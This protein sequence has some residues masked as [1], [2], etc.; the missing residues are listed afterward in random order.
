MAKRF[1]VS[2]SVL[3]SNIDIKFWQCSR[4]L[5]PGVYSVD[6]AEERGLLIVLFAGY[7]TVLQILTLGSIRYRLPLEPLL[8]VIASIYFSTV[9]RQG[10]SYFLGVSATRPK[11]Q[12]QPP[13]R[14]RK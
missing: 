7:V 14:A 6:V 1:G 9:W 11:S 5:S 2:D 12:I 3:Q 13:T 8:I 10:V 4:A